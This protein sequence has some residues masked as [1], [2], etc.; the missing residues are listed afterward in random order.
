MGRKKK[1]FLVKQFV[2]RVQRWQGLENALVKGT[3]FARMTGFGE[4]ELVEWY[5]VEDGLP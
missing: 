4:H 1:G 2:E 3:G 5:E